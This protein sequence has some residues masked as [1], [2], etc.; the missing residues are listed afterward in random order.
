MSN[1]FSPTILW[2]IF[3]L[4]LI[5]I[6]IFTLSFFLLFFGAAALL[7]ALLKVLGLNNFPVE[8]VI[9]SVLGMGGLLL[10]RKKLFAS[11]QAKKNYQIDAN[12]KVRLTEDIKAGEEAKIEYQ[13]ASWTAVNE[14]GVDLH[15]GDQ[16]VILRIES[17]KIFLGPLI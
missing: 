7:V 6:E 10:F 17:V 4:I 13:G 12:Q 9:F 15:R 3:G 11:V 14:S 2:A 1:Y 5:T 8:L 16:A